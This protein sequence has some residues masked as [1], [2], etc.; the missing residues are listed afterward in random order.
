M[1]NIKTK[2]TI[3]GAVTLLVASMLLTNSMSIGLNPQS[4]FAKE[5]KFN[6]STQGIGQGILTG[7]ES[8][9][10]AEGNTLASCNNVGLSLNL[11]DGNSAAAQQ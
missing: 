5:L 2:S 4:I 1:S 7:Q 6:N 8:V 3:L 11:N 9:C 10:D